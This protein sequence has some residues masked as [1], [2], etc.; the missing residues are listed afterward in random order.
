[1]S[2]AYSTITLTARATSAMTA[3]TASSVISF[4]IIRRPTIIAPFFLGSFYLGKLSSLGPF[5]RFA[6]PATSLTTSVPYIFTMPYIVAI[7]PIWIGTIPCIVIGMQIGLG[8][9]STVIPIVTSIPLSFTSFA[10]LAN[11]ANLA[12]AIPRSAGVPICILAFSRPSTTSSDMPVRIMMHHWL[13]LAQ[14]CYGI[15]YL[16]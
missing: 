15:R 10:G 6:I 14:P 11:L 9:L 4:P 5:A 7:D 12:T 16:F 1:M 8:S 13:L 3:I 2:P